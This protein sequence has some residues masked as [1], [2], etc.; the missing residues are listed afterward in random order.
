MI[1]SG[2]KAL[3]EPLLWVIRPEYEPG[4]KG[5]FGQI[6]TICDEVEWVQ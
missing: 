2:Y 1:D 3:Q 4:I 6:S 5:V